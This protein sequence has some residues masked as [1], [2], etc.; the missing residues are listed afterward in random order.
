MYRKIYKNV[1]HLWN[2]MCDEQSLCQWINLIMFWNK[3]IIQFL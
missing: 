1:L 3:C 2:M